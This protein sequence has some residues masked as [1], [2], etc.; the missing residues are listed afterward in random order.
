MAALDF[1]DTVGGGNISTFASNPI[2][3]DPE[4]CVRLAATGWLTTGDLSPG[5]AG[6]VGGL[7][8]GATVELWH[9]P[10]TIPVVSADFLLRGPNTSTGRQW[11]VKISTAGAY[12]FTV[13]DAAGTATTVSSGAVLAGSWNHIIGTVGVGSVV[14]LY[15]NGVQVDSK[16]TF[17]G[18]FN[19]V[20]TAGTADLRLGDEGGEMVGSF[21]TDVAVYRST[22]TASRVSAHYVA[23]T[24]RGFGQQLTGTR[25]ASVLALSS[26]ASAP[27]RIGTGQRTV[28][29]EYMTGIAPKDEIDAAVSV[30][31]VDAVFFVA[32]DGTL[33]YLDAAHRSSSPYNTSQVTIGDA[34]GAE[35]PYED[36]E[37]DYSESF[38]FNEW[39]ATRRGT[40]LVAGVTQTVTDATSISRYFKRVQGLSGPAWIQ[41]SDALAVAT[42]MLAKYKDPQ[43]RITSVSFTTLDPSVSE[44]VMRRELMDKITV[45]RTPP[46]GGA[47]ISQDLFI[48]KIEVSGANDGKPWSVRWAVSPV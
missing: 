5:D 25:I 43:Q 11:E 13:R 28:D 46:G 17:G 23:G 16:N 18:P 22:L 6:E 27:R 42:A 47:R 12:S 26:S 38:L 44:A 3:G 19:N 36:L 33:T 40:A 34:G 10:G 48:Q 24:Q 15:L 35:I 45:K 8:A 2:V 1:V 32:A 21:F 39:D 30:D 29:S 14:T 37:I 20:L 41:D 4:P 7:F 9:N 31:S